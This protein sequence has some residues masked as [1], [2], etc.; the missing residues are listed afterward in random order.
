MVVAYQKKRSNDSS[1]LF[2][3]EW[4]TNQHTIEWWKGDPDSPI[5]SH[6][7]I[8]PAGLSRNVSVESDPGNLGSI[9]RD[10]NYPEGHIMSD[11]DE[12]KWEY[13][14]DH[15]DLHDVVI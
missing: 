13:S 5:E 11:D 1:E 15:G 6:T 14:K 4:W 3:A 10:W 8:A 7:N 9:S 2:G 12:R